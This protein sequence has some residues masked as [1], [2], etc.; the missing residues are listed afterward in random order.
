VDELPLGLDKGREGVGVLPFVE[1]IHA[2]V[3]RHERVD[4]ILR[5]EEGAYGRNE[6]EKEEREGWW[7]WMKRRWWERLF[8]V[9]VIEKEVV[10]EEEV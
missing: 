7:L 9:V 4:I 5:L 3:Q 6:H 1:S 2:I 8:E 10:V